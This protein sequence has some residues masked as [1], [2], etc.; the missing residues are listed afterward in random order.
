MKSLV[1]SMHLVA[2][3]ILA[4]AKLAY[5]SLVG[6]FGRD[7]RSL[8]SYVSTRG[9]GFFTLDLPSLGSILLEGLESGRLVL[10]GPASRRSSARIKVPKLFRGLWLRVFDYS[11]SLRLDPDP[12]A[13]AFL[14]QL[15]DLGKKVTLSCTDARNRASVKEFV[16]VERT[17][18]PPTLR[19]SDDELFIGHHCRSLSF[20]SFGRMQRISA[21][22]DPALFED[23]IGRLSEKD[24]NLLE[25]LDSICRDV[26]TGYGLLDPVTYERDRLLADLP[27]GTKNGPGAVS[28]RTSKQEKFCFDYWPAKLQN[29]FP[30]AYF[31]HRPNEQGKRFT[32]LEHP[33]KLIMVPKTAKTPRLIASEPSYHQWCQQLVKVFLEERT[34]DLFGPIISFRDQSMSHP[35]VRLGSQD[36]SLA[37]V[38]LSAAS[39]RLSCWA[40]E[41]AFA[42]NT[43]LLNA[44]KACRTRVIGPSERVDIDFA[45]LRKFSTMGSALTFPVQSIFF[46]CVALAVL[47]GRPTL[48]SQLNRWGNQVRVYGDDIVIPATGYVDLVRLLTILGLK[49]NLSKSFTKGHFRE[50]CGYDAFLGHDVTPIKPRS[51]D[52]TTPDGRAS[53]IELT[54]NLYLRGYW[55]ASEAARSILPESTLRGLPV[56]DPRSGTVGLVSYLGTNVTDIP[57]RYNEH[58]QQYEARCTTFISRAETTQTDGTDYSLQALHAMTFRQDDSSRERDHTAV[59]KWLI[60]PPSRAGLGRVVKAVTR[61]R[62]SWVV[63]DDW[64]VFNRLAG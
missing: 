29:V 46:A 51:L 4:D 43:S 1:S 48:R 52:P 11:G 3:G 5:P 58:I 16:D 32:N 40:I 33:S 41:R 36:R 25:R 64:T 19:W 28:D 63:F 26:S 2:A 18:R 21:T 56:V 38:D 35:L 34:P 60:R 61:E 12:T 59:L 22:S 24:A 17:T 62:R 20:S 13:V 8:A 10:A 50:S 49:V 37:T 14:R 47:P 54:N 15:A 23:D 7:E 55:K 31:G 27:S 45:Y 44:F 6:E 42:W 9:L 30:I 39:D 53:L 57:I